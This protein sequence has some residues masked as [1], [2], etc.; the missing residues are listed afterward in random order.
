MSKSPKDPKEIFP[1]IVEDYKNL[2]GENLISVIAY[3]SAASA[4]YVPGR[5]D[6][7]LMVI[8]DDAGMDELDRSFDVV[9]KWRKKGVAVPLFLTEEYV[10]TS[11]DVFPIEYLNF[12]KNHALLFGKDLLADLS[13]EK[14]HVRLQCERELK[15][16]LL[17]LREAFIES[18]GR[19]KELEDIIGQ[20]I[21]AFVSIFEALLFLKDKELPERKREI[22]KAACETFEMDPGVFLKFLD[23]KEGKEKLSGPEMVSLYKEYLSHVK[24]LSKLIDQLGG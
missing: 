23:V 3:G 14:E 8:L 17:L 4:D 9:K 12:Q 21:R 22:I 16:K 7:N 18:Q 11:V 13:F 15:G 2:Y 5:S 19:A 10:N 6:I 20:S 1:E 24:K